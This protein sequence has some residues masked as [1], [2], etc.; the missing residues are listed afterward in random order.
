[1]K[2]GKK[3]DHRRCDWDCPKEEVFEGTY[4]CFATGLFHCC[5]EGCTQK[6]K[7]NEYTA[8]CR[9]SGCVFLLSQYE[10]EAIGEFNQ[11]ELL[12]EMIHKVKN[13]QQK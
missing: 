8:I 13:F 5:G 10:M 2:S 6:M 1:M 3:V 4:R 12:L 11:R 7:C 9:V